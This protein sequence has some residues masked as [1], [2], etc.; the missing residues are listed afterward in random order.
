LLLAEGASHRFPNSSRVV[1][2]TQAS[3]VAMVAGML[4]SAL[5]IGAGGE[6]AGTAETCAG[7]AAGLSPVVP[8]AGT[9]A[10]SGTGRRVVWGQPRRISSLEIV[11]LG[12]GQS[13][14]CGREGRTVDAISRPRRLPTPAATSVTEGA[15]K[16]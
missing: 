13:V 3:T 2:T 16:R 14:V 1:R 4:P 11:A 7:V 9:G 15:R 10:V 6:F 8:G 5:G 12:F